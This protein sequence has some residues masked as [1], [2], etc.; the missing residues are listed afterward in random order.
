MKLDLIALLIAADIRARELAK[1]QPQAVEMLVP[2][3]EEQEPPDDDDAPLECA[4]L[5][6]TEM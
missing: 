5:N 1:T 2:P 4:R 3:Y 6:V